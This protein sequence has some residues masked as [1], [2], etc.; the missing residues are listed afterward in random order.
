M[1]EYDKGRSRACRVTV[2]AA[3]V[4]GEARAAPP[5]DPVVGFSPVLPAVAQAEDMPVCWI[6]LD[7]PSIDRPLMHPCRCPSFVH[8]TCIARWQLQSAG[9][10][11][12]ASQHLHRSDRGSWGQC[13]LMSAAATAWGWPGRQDRTESSNAAASSAGV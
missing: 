8:S 1:A 9:T 7:G 13:G 10:R 4:R 2:M 3:E 11:W 12:V 6:C 5:A